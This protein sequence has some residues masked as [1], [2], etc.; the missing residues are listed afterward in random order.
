MRAGK[1]VPVLFVLAALC[2][3]TR[4]AWAGEGQRALEQAAQEAVSAATNS[5]NAKDLPDIKRIAIV[6]LKG[7]GGNRITD[8][9][10][11]G[12]TKT[13][14]EVI[15]RGSS[16]WNMILR[17][18]EWEGPKAD[19]M[20]AGTVRKLGKILGVDALLYGRVGEYGLEL[21]QARVVLNLHLA[22]VETGQ[23]V[24]GEVVT[25]R[26]E[27]SLLDIISS[28]KIYI[29]YGIIALIILVL[30]RRAWGAMTRPR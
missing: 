10:K 6:P 4:P 30:L 20:Q 19:I 11:I 8:L 9:L 15:L 12:L 23:L 28:Y 5:L 29:V 1:I 3:I 27:E 26:A 2:L 17:E 14:Y 16:E 22:N 21:H 24:W 7:E 25:G 13:K 18:I